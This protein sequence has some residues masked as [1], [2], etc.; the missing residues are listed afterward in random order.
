LDNNGVVIDLPAVPAPGTTSII[1]QMLFGVGTQAN[2]ATTGTKLL[3]TTSQG[4]INT[5][6][7][8]TTPMS[9]SFID[10]GSNGLFFGPTTAPT[11]F[12]VCGD[13][14]CPNGNPSVNAT[15]AGTNGINAPVTFVVGDASN[16]FSNGYSVLP[17]LSGPMGNTTDFDW[18]LPFFYGR[19]VFFGIEGTSS[20]LGIGP[21]YAF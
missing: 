16:L 19:R 7:S 17:T 9:G 2:N 21:L 12:T 20:L 13:F 5:T 6:L 15:L 18:G 10:S 8:V 11:I 4:T 14:Y 3:H 1:G